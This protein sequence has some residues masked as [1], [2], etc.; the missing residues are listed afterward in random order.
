M[1][2]GYFVNRL[3]TKGFEPVNS[4]E[5]F[6]EG[7]LTVEMKDKQGEVTI[8]NELYKV[9]PVWMDRGAP[10]TDTHSNRVIGKGINYAKADFTAQDGEVYPAIKVTGKI[11]KNYDLDNEI[12]RKI[13]SGEY[14]GLSF[15]GAT[16]ANRTP[17][18]MK[19]GSIAYALSNLEHYEVAV[20]KDPA[21][22]M[23]IITDYNPIAKSV[24]H[25]EKRGD[26]MI[27]KTCDNFGCF[28]TKPMPDGNGGKGNFDHCV[29]VNQDKRDPSAYCGQIKHDTEDSKKAE[30]INKVLPVS[31][32]YISG[33]KKGSKFCPNCGRDNIKEDKKREQEYRDSHGG[34]APTLMGASPRTGGYTC[35]NCQKKPK[36]NMHSP[37]GTGNEKGAYEYL[38]QEEFDAKQKADHSNS[39]GDQHSMYNQNTGRETWIGQGLPQPKVTTIC[40]PSMESEGKCIEQEKPLDDS[41]GRAKPHH[42]NLGDDTP[43]GVPKNVK[44]ESKLDREGKHQQ[45]KAFLEYLQA[46]LKKVE[47][48]QFGAGQRGLGHDKGSVQG[49]GDSAQITPVQE[50]KKQPKSI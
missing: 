8:V 16:K 49:S 18:R 40:E 41:G 35:P 10:I 17:M 21:V 28:I 22:P 30:D 39:M 38:T 3:L 48:G 33:G 43:A 20:C 12:W 25:T 13:K 7:Y 11:F 26:K 31:D 44:D 6:F 2:E 27:V 15:G 47:E 24:L 42:A 1:T 46:D 50:E 5:R 29:S 45:K 14:K 9:L 32:A 23:A 4:D 19:D 34:S 36:R 37:S